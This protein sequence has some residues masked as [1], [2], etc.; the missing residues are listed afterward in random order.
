MQS[1]IPKII[2]QIWIGPKERPSKFMDSWRTNNPDFEYIFWNEEEIKKRELKLQCVDKINSMPEINGK[3][4]I[5][6]WEILY[7]YGGVFFDADSISIAPIDDHLM[8]SLA[9]ASYENESSRKGLIATV[10]MGFPKHHPLCLSAINWILKNNISGQMAW[11]SVGPGLI[12]RLYKSFPDITIFPSYYFLPIHFSGN[13]YMGHGKVYAHQ[14]WGSTKKNYDIMNN[15]KIPPIFSTP[16]DRSVSIL[17]SS[18]NTKILYVRECLDSIKHQNGH[19]MIE[20]IWINDG[21][22]EE[23]TQLLEVALNEFKVSTRYCNVIYKK[24]EQNMGLSYCLNEGVN[25]CN[26]EIIF[27]MD[28]D[29]LMITDRLL[30]QMNFMKTHLDYVI[31]GSNVQY[32]KENV[33]TKK[34]NHPNI[35]KWDDYKNIKSHWFMNHPTLCFRKSAVLEVGNYNNVDR[36]VCEDLELELKLMK[37]YGKIFNFPECLV[38]Y[39]IHEDQITFNGKSNTPFWKEYRDKLIQSFF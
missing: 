15:I 6:R 28:S 11:R 1:H 13:I 9:F 30:V 24:M 4:D 33:Y 16:K 18:Y 37:K 26:N 17:I 32:F 14:E 2:H 39:R 12:T 5:I 3:A 20:L 21:S 27:R 10:A 7:N 25:M 22:T 36:S 34:T 38:L 8:S 23:N 35:L 19:I 29:D 31:C